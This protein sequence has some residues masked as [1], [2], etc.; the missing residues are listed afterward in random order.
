MFGNSQKPFGAKSGEQNGCF[1][2]VIDFWA[3][4]FFDR[5]HLVRWSIVMVE[6]TVIG[7]NFKPFSMHSFT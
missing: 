1:I 2:S 4:N 6:N 3:R 7:P 5:E